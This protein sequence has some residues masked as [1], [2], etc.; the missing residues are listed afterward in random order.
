ML[1]GFPLRLVVPGWY[2]TYWV[3]ALNEIRVLSEKFQGFW[4][5]KAYR[6]PK[7]TDGNES[8]D[9]LATET[10]AINRLALRSLFVRPEPGAR[11]PA[12]V[13]YEIQGIAF[14]SGGGIERVEVSIDAGRAW[15]SARL[16]PDLG[17]YSWRRWRFGWVP[18]ATGKYHLSVRA[19]SRTGE[20]QATALW[21]RS[22][23]M[24]N[25]VEE[26]VVEVI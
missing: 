14:D 4:M 15:E 13:P 20:Q 10:I 9:H 3:K 1:N 24:R 8:P 6:I 5:D 21:N 2:G 25:V 16:D 17:K 11:I 18:G 7:A 12:K 22:G 19:F 23:Y 26:S